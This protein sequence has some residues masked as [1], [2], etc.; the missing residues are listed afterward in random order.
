[1]TST[2][3]KKP[4]TKASKKFENKRLPVLLGVLALLIVVQGVILYTS[5][6]P[7]RTNVNKSKNQITFNQPT[8][9]TLSNAK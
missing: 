3:T 2:Q 6:P 5:R 1:M 9:K 8:N 4:K 7:K